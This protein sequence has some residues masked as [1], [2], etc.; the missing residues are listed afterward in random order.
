[1]VEFTAERKQFEC[2]ELE[3]DYVYTTLNVVSSQSQV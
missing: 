2:L 1:M 3:K